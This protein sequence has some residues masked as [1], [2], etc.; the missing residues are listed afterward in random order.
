MRTLSIVLAVFGTLFTYLDWSLLS[1]FDSIALRAGGI[2]ILAILMIAILWVPLV[3][4]RQEGD[5]T[6]L[7]QRLVLWLAYG[8]AGFLSFA[9][10]FS[11]GRDLL[12][13][14]TPLDLRTPVAS[15]A[16][17]LAALLS[18][19]WGML[20]AHQGVR[21]Y[22]V[23][24]SLPNL[25]VSLR[26]LRI[27]QITDLHVGPTIRRE[28][29]EN[30]V[31]IANEASP[32]LVVLTGDLV[33]G[34]PADLE[35]EVAPLAGLRARFG[36]YYCTGN[37][38]YYWD[39]Q[40]WI[41]HFRKLGL[42]PLVNEHRLIAKDA[43]RLAIAGVPDPAARMAKLDGPD[44]A[45]A[46]RGIPQEAVKVVLCHQPGFAPEAEKAGFDLQLSGHTHGGQFFP[47]TL[48]AARVHR[49]NYGLHRLGRLA[50]YVSRGTG[51]WGP[52]VRL[53]APAEVTLLELGDA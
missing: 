21:L 41:A 49:H 29:V 33:D 11:L 26:G 28:F 27:V 25:P 35:N 23:R 39:G 20:G 16:V 32:D 19:T 31:R 38:E 46:A 51:Y 44:F 17:S 24:V 34:M 3:Y 53:G 10:V 37:H 12:D 36:T 18:F 45:A 13:L 42:E 5:E 43:A 2:L 4:W 40:A 14:L 6:T 9:L 48:V 47:W 8:G 52:P 22:P 50:I 1:P 30:V 7:R 15:A